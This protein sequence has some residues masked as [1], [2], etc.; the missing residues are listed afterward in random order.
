M[1][2]GELALSPSWSEMDHP[3]LAHL[4]PER[5][6]TREGPGTLSPSAFLQMF[7]VSVLLHPGL[8]ALSPK[9]GDVLVA[10]LG[11]GA[12]IVTL[13]HHFPLLKITVVEVDPNVVTFTKAQ[14]PL[15]RWL[16]DVKQSIRIILMDCVKFIAGAPPSSFDIIILDAYNE[17]AQLADGILTDAFMRHVGR[18]L[19]ADGVLLVNVIGRFDLAIAGPLTSAI[20]AVR[21][22]GFRHASLFPLPEPE[23]GEPEKGIDD[24]ILRNTMVVASRI[25]MRA[26][27]EWSRF[28]VFPQFAEMRHWLE[29]VRLG[30]VDVDG[31]V[32]M[33][34]ERTP[35]SFLSAGLVKKLNRRWLEAS[36]PSARNIRGRMHP[37]MNRQFLLV[38]DAK[39]AAQVRRSVLDTCV[40]KGGCPKGWESAATSTCV[41][42]RRIDLV[43]TARWLWNSCVSVSARESERWL[44]R[45]REKSEL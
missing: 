16:I 14:F 3:S 29:E 2:Q 13:H 15:L 33:A 5:G 4:R 40:A 12:G 37:P 20:G 28:V 11:A 17:M 25:P 32:T 27:H 41:F 1:F 22:S 26:Y 31:R 23:F 18:A 42:F 44:G 43:Y 6:V 24:S 21:T 9:R 34:T 10:G 35:L 7:M 38:D 30:Y 19:R 39:L 8:G 45:P 36:G